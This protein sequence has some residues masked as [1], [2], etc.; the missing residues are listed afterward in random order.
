MGLKCGNTINFGISNIDFNSLLTIAKFRVLIR[1]L[2]TA[3][4]HQ[5]SLNYHS[6]KCKLSCFM[7]EQMKSFPF[8]D[9]N[10]LIQREMVTLRMN[11]KSLEKKFK[12]K[13]EC[14]K[15]LI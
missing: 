8:S 14:R 2:N 12:C 5:Q 1:S 11:I 6:L 15:R 7:M 13:S 4:L 9:N 3:D 10:E